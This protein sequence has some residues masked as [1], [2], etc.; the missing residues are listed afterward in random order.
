MACSYRY[1]E[2]LRILSGCETSPEKCAEYKLFLFPRVQLL[3]QCN[4]KNTK[5]IKD[6]DS[7]MLT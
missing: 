5:I 1:I 3:R 6:C 4:K 7:Y 2:N